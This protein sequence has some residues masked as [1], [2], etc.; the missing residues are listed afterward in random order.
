MQQGVEDHVADRA[1]VDKGPSDVVRDVRAL[2]DHP[3]HPIAD[4]GDRVGGVSGTV[5]WPAAITDRKDVV[6]DRLDQAGLRREMMLHE[7]ERDSRRGGDPTERLA[8]VPW[9]AK[10]F[11]AA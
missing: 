2:G 6:V 1:A 11:S 9:V 5:A 8:A 7:P 3:G 4:L 10:L